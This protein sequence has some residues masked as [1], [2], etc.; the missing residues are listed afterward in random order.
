[1]FRYGGIEGEGSF[2]RSVED[3]LTSARLDHVTRALAAEDAAEEAAWAQDQLDKVK[4]QLEESLVS[5]VGIDE[6]SIDEV[7]DLVRCVCV[8]CDVCGRGGGGGGGEVT[9][10]LT[11][12]MPRRMHIE[13]AN[14]EGL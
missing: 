8:G 10:S 4:G 14:F 11:R 12:R 9:V 3:H 1:M 2:L 13:L 5:I 7:R 6:V